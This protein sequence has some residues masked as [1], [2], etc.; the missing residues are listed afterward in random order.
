MRLLESVN[1]SAVTFGIGVMLLL[2]GAA[3]TAVSSA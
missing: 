1:A 2:A 3:I